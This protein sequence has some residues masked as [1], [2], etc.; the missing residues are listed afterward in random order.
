MDGDNQ[1][2]QEPAVLWSVEGLAQDK[3]LRCLR[4]CLE[5]FHSE[6]AFYCRL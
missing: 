2:L 1:N 5:R 6:E 3:S 4:E